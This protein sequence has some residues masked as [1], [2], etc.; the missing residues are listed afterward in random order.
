MPVNVTNPVTVGAA[1]KKDHFDRCFDNTVALYGGNVAIASQ[2]AG[3]VITAVSSTQLGRVNG[4]GLLQLNGASAP[5]IATE[6]AASLLTGTIDNAR[7]DAELQALAGLT[8]A[9]DKLP[10]FTGSG[11]AALADVTA[12]AR[13]L[14]DDADAA[15]VLATLGISAAHVERLHENSGSDTTAS[16]A[17]VDTYAMASGL[18]DKD[19]LVVLV[20]HSNPSG[21]GVVATSLYNAT[22]SLAVLAGSTA[23]NNYYQDIFIISCD[24]SSGTKVITTGILTDGYVPGTIANFVTNFNGNWTLALRHGTISG[25]ATWYWRWK[26]FRFK[27]A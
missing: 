18:S 13:T 16:A 9:A 15:T 8:S 6:I 10:Y 26:I 20:Q 22:D 17:N 14:L 19:T 2:G 23:N 3:D 1:T 24:K 12:F 27:G 25:G 21:S 7:L 4:T 11:T 5:T